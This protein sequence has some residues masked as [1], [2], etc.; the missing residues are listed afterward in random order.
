MKLL[1]DGA[2]LQFERADDAVAAA[3]DVTAGTADLAL[4]AARAGIA[5]GSLIRRDGD[6]SAIP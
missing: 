5:V 2:M 3:A 6:F 4:P 1:G